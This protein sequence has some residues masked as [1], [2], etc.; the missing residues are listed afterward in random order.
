ML[1]IFLR[2]NLT[3][4][5][6]RDYIKK[7]IY[8]QLGLSE[9]ISLLRSVKKNDFEYLFGLAE[10][11]DLVVLSL[12]GKKIVIPTSDS[13][14]DQLYKEDQKGM[15]KT[16]RAQHFTKKAIGEGLI[17]TDR[18]DWTNARKKVRGLFSASHTEEL[19]SSIKKSIEEQVESANGVF[20]AKQFFNSVTI[21]VMGDL[22]FGGLDKADETIILSV[23]DKMIEPIFD[24]I[25]NPLYFLS[26][27]FDGVRKNQ[28]ILKN[29]LERC[30][31]QARL[32]EQENLV[33]KYFA[34]GDN[35]GAVSNLFAAGYE[36]TASA[37]C[38]MFLELSDAPQILDTVRHELRSL[39]D[40]PSMTDLKSSIPMTAA[41]FD[42][43]LR[44]YP[45][46]WVNGRIADNDILI[47]GYKI[48]AKSDIL[49]SPFIFHHLE[50]YWEKPEEF[51]PERFLHIDKNTHDSYFFPFG[52]GAR[53]CIGERV[54]KIQAYLT[55]ISIFKNFEVE[56]LMN[57]KEVNRKFHFTLR[58]AEK[59]MLKLKPL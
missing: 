45:P 22:F 5:V 10:N 48:R 58:P 12:P 47:G 54:A 57:K 33:K 14:L 30:I 31:I 9:S 39:Q 4:F 3:T 41:C 37:L 49:L 16:P 51:V 32:K 43:T 6:K 46:A 17:S 23:V 38:W 13:V 26:N 1:W 44:L 35:V 7:Y 19:F 42:E 25:V 40:A 53:A 11:H 59:I 29:T 27:P 56:F 15:I 18:E 52:K 55:I 8:K 28:E 36:T 2:R 20:D 24:R 34:E 21:R 50:K